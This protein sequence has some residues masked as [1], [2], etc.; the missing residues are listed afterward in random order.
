MPDVYLNGKP[1]PENI[2]EEVQEEQRTRALRRWRALHLS[3]NTPSPCH[4]NPALV[5]GHRPPR[6]QLFFEGTRIK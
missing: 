2:F 1:I 5:K 4:S 6:S 3:S